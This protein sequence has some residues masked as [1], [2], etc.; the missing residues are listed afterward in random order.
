MTTTTTTPETTTN[1]VEESLFLQALVQQVRA[2]DHYGVYRSWSDELVLSNFVVSKE[3][4][5]KISVEGDVD[6]ATQLRVLCFYRAI[7]AC[8]EKETGKLCQVVTDLSH[9]GFGW[10]IIWTGRLMVLSRTLRDAQRFGYPSLQ[11]LAAQGERLVE[12]GIQTIE[13][14]PDAAN[15]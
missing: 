12:S 4:K 8:I 15:A 3:K 14:F 7:A 13:K 9:E 1:I 6:S 11:K 10:A 5:S 2:Q